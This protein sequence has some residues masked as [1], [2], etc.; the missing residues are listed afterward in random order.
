MVDPA[1]VVTIAL[2]DLSPAEVM[3][4]AE[5]DGVNVLR[6]RYMYTGQLDPIAQRMLGGRELALV[7]TVSLDP[8]T[9]TGTLSLVAEAEPGRLHGNANITIAATSTGARRVLDGEFT[10]KVPLMGGAVERRLLPGILARFDVEADATA[11]KL[12]A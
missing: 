8:T 4:H 12:G 2:P 11:A 10:V 7:Q 3:D 6:V 5:H 1:F 9:T